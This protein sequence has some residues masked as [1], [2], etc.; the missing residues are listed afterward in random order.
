MIEELFRV[1]IISGAVLGWI[2][3]ILAA[4][5][6]LRWSKFVDN[7]P[8]AHDIISEIIL[9]VIFMDNYKQKSTK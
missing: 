4:V 8:N 6:Y 5:L 2:F 7:N 9:R 1:L 3:L